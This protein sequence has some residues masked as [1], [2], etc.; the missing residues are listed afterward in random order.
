MNALA[1]GSFSATKPATCLRIV[2]RT[3]AL[4]SLCQQV[5]PKSLLE[6]HDH[7]ELAWMHT[8]CMALHCA[9][10]CRRVAVVCMLHVGRI[11]IVCL[12]DLYYVTGVIGNL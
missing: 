2:G 12:C 9:L 10:S 6:Q 1:A 7:K 8:L 4:V 3:P 11:Y 5:Y